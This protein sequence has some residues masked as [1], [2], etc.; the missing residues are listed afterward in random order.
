[1]GWPQ[2]QLFDIDAFAALSEGTGAGTARATMALAAIVLSALLR[3]FE[4]V[5]DRQ[6]C[7]YALPV[8]L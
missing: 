1:M 4:L 3:R 2:T 5:G 8:A 7:G 6:P